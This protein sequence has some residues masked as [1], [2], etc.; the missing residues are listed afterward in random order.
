MRIESWRIYQALSLIAALTLS[1]LP[2][3]D[4]YAPWQPQWVVMTVI[5]WMSVRP[6]KT[7]F[8]MAWSAGLLSDLVVG[9]WIGIHVLS[10]C[11]IVFLCARFYRVL[12]LS[13]TLQKIFPVG[14]LL[15]LHMGYLHLFSIFLSNVDLGLLYWASLPASLLVWPVLHY[16]LSKIS[17]GDSGGLTA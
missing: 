15:V 11:L 16:L 13:S 12:Q 6:E 9:S 10:Y 14:L 8:G 4:S 3:P 7:G 2:L 17:V 5:F 1:A